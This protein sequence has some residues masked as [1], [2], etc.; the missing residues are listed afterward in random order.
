MNKIT[1]YNSFNYSNNI[2]KNKF[3]SETFMSKG[4][5]TLKIIIVRET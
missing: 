4:Y 1:N 5:I 2:I 3:C